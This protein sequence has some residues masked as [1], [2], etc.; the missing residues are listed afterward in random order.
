[1]A[2]GVRDDSVLHVA[3]GLLA[4]VFYGLRLRKARA[5]PSPTRRAR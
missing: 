3:A 5:P 2:E 4:R 1:M